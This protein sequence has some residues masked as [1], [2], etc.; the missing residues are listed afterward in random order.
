MTMVQ[1]LLTRADAVLREGSPAVEA[2]HASWRSRLAVLIVFGATYGA[3][4]GSY[5]D[6][7][8][9]RPLQMAY[10]A[11]KVPLML[12]ASFAV[13]LPA[14]F[15]LNTFFGL[16]DDFPR[17]VA[18]LV[19]TQAGLTVILA[20][21]API[22]AFVY[23]SGIDYRPAILF[24]GLMF[25]TASVAAQ[26]ILRRSYRGLILANPRHRHLLRTWLVLY[27]FVGVQ[28]GWLLR[29]F[30]GDP[31]RPTQFF[32]EGGWSNAYVVVIEMVWGVVVG[33]SPR[34]GG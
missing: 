5:G 8:G 4:M 14:F 34:A 30:I 24:N 13:G 19:A 32:R 27:V 25:A 31:G 29:P 22:T 21:L 10:S 7:P 17:V 28:M 6:P 16:R 20:S 11:T 2:P 3:V 9:G 23:A 33:P 26:A 12:A 15:A 1:S 18:A